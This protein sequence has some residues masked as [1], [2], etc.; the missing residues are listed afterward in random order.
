MD[1]KMDLIMETKL[2]SSSLDLIVDGSGFR[3][4]GNQ[5]PRRSSGRRQPK[6]RPNRFSGKGNYSFPEFIWLDAVGLTGLEFLNS[7]NMVCSMK[8]TCLWEILITG[9]STVSTGQKKTG[10]YFREPLLIR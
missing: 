6:R 1:Q 4:Y 3:E 7:S 8:T 2:I 5:T 9:I 10:L